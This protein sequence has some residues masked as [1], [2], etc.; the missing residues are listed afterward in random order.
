MEFQVPPE[1][2]AHIAKLQQENE[3]LREKVEYRDEIIAALRD[4]LQA[5]QTEF[6]LRGAINA[7]DLATL[8]KQGGNAR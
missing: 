4:A 2:A 5:L 1:V 3:L 6:Q 8:A 7:A